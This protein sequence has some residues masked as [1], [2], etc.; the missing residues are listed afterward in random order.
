MKP[1][2]KDPGHLS[3][4]ARYAALFA[5]W[6]GEVQPD[7][8][9]KVRVLSRL[10]KDM[11]RLQ[12]TFRRAAE[13]HTEVEKAQAKK[14]KREDD[15]WREEKKAVFL[16]PVQT[17]RMA[18]AYGGGELGLHFARL[19]YAIDNDL[20]MPWITD[21]EAYKSGK[22][23]THITFNS[24]HSNQIRPNQTTKKIHSK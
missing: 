23:A 5:Q 2:P 14:E 6:D 9:I 7:L 1:P 24:P 4:S 16:E 12:R 3:P 20:P 8:E 15:E 11:A 10:T 18:M 22:L 21:P 17:A 19:A 13:Y